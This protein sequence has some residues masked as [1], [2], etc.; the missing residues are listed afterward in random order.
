VVV[1]WVHHQITPSNHYIIEMSATTLDGAW[2]ATPTS[3]YNVGYQ[4]PNYD[5]LGGFSAAVDDAGSA[6]V[7]FSHYNSHTGPTSPRGVYY[8]R[9]SPGMD[10]EYPVKIPSSDTASSSAVLASDGQ[11]AMAVWTTTLAGTYSLVASRYTISKQFVAPVPI[12]DPDLGGYIYLGQDY[13]LASNG[14]SFF[15][16]WSQAVGN[17]MNTYATRFDIAT[18]EWDA[19]PALVSD[20]VA[21]SGQNRAIGVDA[22][23]NAIVAFDQEGPTT[24]MVVAARYVASTREWSAAEPLTADGNDYG[25]PRLAV[26]PNGVA[27]LFY[28]PTYRDG[29]LRG[30][31]PRGEF[32]LFR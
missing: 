1:A 32:R 12:N 15:A 24:S 20:G 14:A 17:L 13:A 5:S 16:T 10:W 11:G 29:P 23:G 4:A 19:L 3:N 6:L 2:P 7:V 8:V 25:F 28:G 26:A 30:P 18:S 31:A 9:K 21:E 22:H 27:S